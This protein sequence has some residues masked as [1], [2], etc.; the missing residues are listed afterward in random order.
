ML[1]S[2]ESGLCEPLKNSLTPWVMS[3]IVGEGFAAVECWIEVIGCLFL[4]DLGGV[5]V[6]VVLQYL[7][8]VE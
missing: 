3:D 2:V 6:V 1:T 5:V 7:G 8:N 4:S